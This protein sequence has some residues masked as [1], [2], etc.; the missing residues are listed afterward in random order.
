MIPDAYARLDADWRLSHCNSL[1]YG[2][3]GTVQR[4]SFEELY[5][6]YYPS[7]VA[8]VR[9]EYHLAEGDA[10]SY[11]HELL[12]AHLLKRDEIHDVRVWLRGAMADDFRAILASG[13]KRRTR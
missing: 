8:A 10:E 13:R 7:L 6:R 5:E 3:C 9:R 4:V 12:L 2:H 11:V 1:L